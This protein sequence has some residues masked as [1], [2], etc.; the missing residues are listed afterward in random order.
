MEGQSSA[1][2][3]AGTLHSCALI[4]GLANMDHIFDWYEMSEQL[5]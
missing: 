3:F 4:G 2:Q 5:D 1:P